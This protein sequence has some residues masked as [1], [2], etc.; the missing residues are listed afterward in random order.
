MQTSR[1]KKH[2]NPP[3][4]ASCAAPFRLRPRQAFCWIKKTYFD[5]KQTY[6]DYKQTFFD[7]KKTFLDYKINY[8]APA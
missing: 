7:Y 8:P 1:R 6:F 2:L 4:G 5:Y 3:Q